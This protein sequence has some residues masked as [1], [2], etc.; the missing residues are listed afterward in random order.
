VSVVLLRHDWMVLGLSSL[1]FV[2]SALCLQSG[3]HNYLLYKGLIPKVT[4]VSNEDG[5][6]TTVAQMPSLPRYHFHGALC[7][8]SVDHSHALMQVSVSLSSCHGHA[9][10]PTVE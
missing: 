5:W 4:V 6:I 7:V 10:T 3:L 2:W 8:G 1:H 9:E